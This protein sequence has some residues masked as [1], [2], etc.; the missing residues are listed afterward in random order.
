MKN[1]IIYND[2]S[3]LGFGDCINKL[4]YLYRRYQ[5]IDVTF[6]FYDK[7]KNY[8]TF[9]FIQSH[10]FQPPPHMK[11][12]V[13]HDVFIRKNKGY[14]S[15]YKHDYWPC[16]TKWSQN[17]SKKIAINF[18]KKNTEYFDKAKNFY[19]TDILKNYLKHY[20]IIELYDKSND[21]G[22][23]NII[24]D[25]FDCVDE[26]LKILKDCNLFI[27]SEG[28]WAHIARSMRVPTILYFSPF[29]DKTQTF[30]QNS[31]RKSDKKIQK[32]VKDVEN[33]AV[34]AMKFLKTGRFD[35]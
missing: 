34:E 22:I 2:N 1:V 17:N 29:D 25:P 20:E 27:T 8:Y 15:L 14:F 11:R 5:N 13:N 10:L 33:M 32:Y 7:D 35:V 26:N 30:Y 16:K 12:I 3:A 6:D 23:T 18:Y 24:D 9:L 31:I 28:A 4:S 19:Q 21:K